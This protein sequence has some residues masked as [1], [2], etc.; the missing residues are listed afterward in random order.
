[1]AM[2]QPHPLEQF[3]G[4][5]V[6]INR[7][8]P[9]S[10][11]GKLLF[12]K[13]DL[14]VVRTREGIVYVNAAHIKSFNVADGSGGSRSGGSGGSQS[15]GSRGSRSGSGGVSGNFVRAHS[16]PAAVMA[17]RHQ[18][19]QI[20]RGGPEKVE[21]FIADANPTYVILLVKKSVVQIPLFHVKSVSPQNKSRGNKSGKSNQS[22]ASNKSGKSNQ[23]G[24][25]NKSRSGGANRSC[26][27]KSSHKS[28]Y[29]ATRT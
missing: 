21:G 5:E 29:H 11:T 23:S 17:L 16:F 22:G 4:S 15:G 14:L 8:G 28:R 18:F 27:N 12:V 25:S 2:H 6:K 24:A 10:I 3:V 13:H 9:D 1:M 20:N 19:V 7:G 26:S